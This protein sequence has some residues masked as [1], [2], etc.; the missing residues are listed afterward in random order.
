MATSDLIPT[1][2]TST[3][4]RTP[5]YLLMQLRELDHWVSM[6]L[7]STH[8]LYFRPNIFPFIH[9]FWVIIFI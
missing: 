9:G 2:C 3:R 6:T 8:A 1:S 7:N 5:V 4:N